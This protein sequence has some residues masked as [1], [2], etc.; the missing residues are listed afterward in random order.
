[1]EI[2]SIDENDDE[3]VEFLDPE[4][5]DDSFNLLAPSGL[6]YIEDLTIQN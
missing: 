6:N 1:M 5:E 4:F 3:D 2:I